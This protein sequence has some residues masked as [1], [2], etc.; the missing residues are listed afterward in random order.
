MCNVFVGPYV[1]LFVSDLFI[2]KYIF[3]FCIITLRIDKVLLEYT[4]R[5]VRKNKLLLFK[6]VQSS[7]NVRQNRKMIEFKYDIHKRHNRRYKR[8]YNIVTCRSC[9]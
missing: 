9:I 3:V 4:V 1:V 5:R 8:T 6:Y 7:V 2:Y